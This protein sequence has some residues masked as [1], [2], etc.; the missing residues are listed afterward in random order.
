MSKTILSAVVLCVALLLGLST[1]QAQV[2]S[3]TASEETVDTPDLTVLS[4]PEAVN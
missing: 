3:T 4:S 1:T 2:L